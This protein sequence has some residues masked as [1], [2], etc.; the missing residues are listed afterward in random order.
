M[1]EEN[2]KSAKNARIRIDYS[3]KKPNVKFSYPS[4]E[5]QS[6]GSMFP[7]IFVIMSTIG[8]L[9]YFFMFGIFNGF[10]ETSASQVNETELNLS[11]YSD[12]V[13]FFEEE[14]IMNKTYEKLFGKIE[15]TNSSNNYFQQIKTIL[16]F[17]EEN[18]FAPLLMIL[19]SFIVSCIIYFPF[20]SKWKEIYPKI[21]GNMGAKKVSRFR[22]KDII[23][24]NGEYYCELPV[25]SNIILDYTA[26]EDFSK[27]LNLFEIREHKF[28][29]YIEQSKIKKMLKRKHGKD[30]VKRK[31]LNEW[32]WY[33][34]FYFNEKPKKGYIE[35]IYK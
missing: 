12:F 23:E 30:E 22:A 1:R 14:A 15:G 13:K 7:M 2:G 24:S 11:N 4:E 34:R 35:V 26:T 19:I 5:H 9:F 27:Y 28:K 21:Q 33:A 31:Q 32:I 18:H 20:R 16:K 6:E 8:L 3:K 25:F 17:D 10:V 29:Y